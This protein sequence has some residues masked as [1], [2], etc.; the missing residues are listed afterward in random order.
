MC[1]WPLSRDRVD[2][3][4]AKRYSRSNT[5]SSGGWVVQAVQYLAVLVWVVDL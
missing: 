4:L 1:V 5:Q 2:S 3:M